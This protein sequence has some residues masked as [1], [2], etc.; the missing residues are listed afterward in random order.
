L[1]AEQNLSLWS[2]ELKSTLVSQTLM[3]L[4]TTSV[5]CWVAA[6]TADPRPGEAKAAAAEQAKAV[7]AK[8]PPSFFADQRETD[9]YWVERL[10]A[11]DVLMDAAAVIEALPKVAATVTDP[12]QRIK[13]YEDVAAKFFRNNRVNDQLRI[14]ELILGDEQIPPGRRAWIAS[15]LG[16]DWILSNDFIRGSRLLQT[17]TAFLSKTSAEELRAL[18]DTVAMYI[19]ASE[20][21]ML[22]KKSEMQQAAQKQIAIETLYWNDYTAA[23]TDEAR[24]KAITAWADNVYDYVRQQG[25]ANRATQALAFAKE[26]NLHPLAGKLRPTTRAHLRTALGIALAANGL[27]EAALEAANESI[28]IFEAAKTPYVHIGYNLAHLLRAR[29]LFTLDRTA[30]AAANIANIM[31]ARGESQVSAGNFI[32]DELAVLDAASHGNWDEARAAATAWQGRWQ[33]SLGSE[34][35]WTKLA[36]SA[37]MLVNLRDPQY[38]LSRSAAERFL[39]SNLN[40]GN[41]WAD[42]TQRDS[43]Y[44]IAA[45]EEILQ[46]IIDG[47]GKLI[48]DD[49]TELGFSVAE[50]LRTGASQAALYDGAA[51]LAAADP[52]LRALIEK[53]QAFRSSRIDSRSNY[54][55]IAAQTERL[56]AK[57]SD[58]LVISRQKETVLAAEKALEAEEGRLAEVRNE[59]AR[60]FPVYQ[61]LVNPRIP[62]PKELAAKLRPNE[63]YVSLYTGQ[64]LGAAFV[65]TADGRLSL[66]KVDQSRSLVLQS[67][68]K[69]RLPFDESRMPAAAG[70]W[71]GFDPAAAFDLYR[72]WLAP[73]T[74]ALGKADSIHLAAGG[75]LASVPWAATLIEPAA[76]L[77]TA[78]WWGS[79]KS[80]SATPGAS[81]IVLSRSIAS[82]LGDKPFMAFADPQ[83]SNQPVNAR[84]AATRGKLVRSSSGV[85]DY[86]KVTPL[87][88]TLDEARAVASALHADPATDVI[89]GSAATR[90]RVLAEKLDNRRVVAYATHGVLPGEI[91]RITKPALAMAFE[92]KGTE[93]SLLTTDDIVTLRL[94]ADWIILSAC[95]TGLTESGTGEAVSGM[96]RAFFAAGAKSILA[97]Q[98]A[99]ESESAKLLV[100]ETL[101]TYANNPALGK[102]QALASAQR[103]MIEGK[104]GALFQH[105]FFWAPYFMIGEPLR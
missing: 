66:H 48:D 92:G 10:R 13:A 4:L 54:A 69:M 65:V 99:V 3:V 67:V 103:S 81:S 60:R 64:R 16:R 23:V 104:H 31:R 102:A 1:S 95:N 28:R 84:A 33:R 38:K 101:G 15:R 88:E 82:K 43:V 97:T 70:Q 26:A 9:A 79:N 12:L 17:A 77:S 52:E 14:R 86:T 56:A 49:A 68:R 47:G 18:P 30:E 19:A 2:V 20:G 32:A 25:V 98:W 72:V 24:L 41:R 57:S 61:E 59:I 7:L 44:D 94:S 5:S 46:R 62:Q 85:F 11:A 37:L 36:G 96:A 87:P 100:V 93:D 105:P 6:Q 73:S 58:E 76:S 27:Y 35:A 42:S 45:I 71:G 91:P 74:P 50:F 21:L 90:S 55:R 22:Y 83:F 34:S 40:I 39:A 51:K 8:K 78:K 29:V 75:A 63:A 80:I 53:E 89:S